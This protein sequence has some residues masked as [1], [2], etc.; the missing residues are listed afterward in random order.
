MVPSNSKSPIGLPPPCPKP[1]SPPREQTPSRP[2]DCLLWPTPPHLPC[3]PC[4]PSTCCLCPVPSPLAFLCPL[5]SPLLPCSPLSQD[6]SDLFSLTPAP[7]PSHPHL[8]AVDLHTLK[9]PLLTGP[10]LSPWPTPT[11]SKLLQGKR[12]AREPNTYLGDL[13][14]DIVSPLL[15]LG[16]YDLPVTGG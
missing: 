14:S 11:P 8:Q 1:P 13:L 7:E 15:Y 10:L 2:C 3:L 6:L 16:C 5:P 12:R 4:A 9:S